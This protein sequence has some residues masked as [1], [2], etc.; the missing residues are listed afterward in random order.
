VSITIAERKPMLL[1]SLK[2]CC[3]DCHGR[4]IRKSR[5]RGFMETYVLPFI[6]LR[7]YRCMKCDLRFPGLFFASR[8]KQKVSERQAPD[9]PARS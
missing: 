8:S 1:Y 4:D 9:D 7:P 3:P 5:R 6:L 2:R